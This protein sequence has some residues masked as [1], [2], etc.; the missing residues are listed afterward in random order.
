[1]VTVATKLDVP[2]KLVFEGPKKAS[3]LGLGDIVVPG[4]FV[5]LCLR[6]D[7]FLYYHRQKKQVPIDLKT[8]DENSGQVVTSTQ[9]KPM[10]VRPDYVNPKSQ[11]GNWFWTTGLGRFFW[12]TTDATTPALKAARFPKTYFHAAMAGYLIGMMVTLLMLLVFKHAQPALLYLVP[13]VVFAVWIVGLFRGELHEMWI[14]TEDGSLDKE[15]VVV[16][17]DGNGNVIKKVEDGHEKKE[18]DTKALEKVSSD[19]IVNQEDVAA[20]EDKVPTPTTVFA[21]TIEAPA[22][23]SRRKT[24]TVKQHTE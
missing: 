21:F 1:M 18:A 17:V 11:W 20:D 5:G 2:I 12:Q 6:F 7:H 19:K 10:V 13:G 9:T 23:L 3:M 24:R 22:S 14:Y 4:M 8:T 16:E 15:E